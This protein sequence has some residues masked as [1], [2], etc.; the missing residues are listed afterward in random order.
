[1][2]KSMAPMEMRFAERPVR[3][4]MPKAK[5]AAKGMVTAAMKVM[6]GSP[7]MTSSTSVTRVMPAITTCQTVWVVLS[8]SVG[9]VVE[10]LDVHA[11]RQQASVVEVVD[12]FLEAF[13]SGERF[14]VF[15]EQD[16][17]DDDVVLL[18]GADLTEARLEAFSYFGDVSDRDRGA[19][20][21]S[22]DDCC[23]VGCRCVPVRWRGR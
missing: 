18:V 6:R 4:I 8:M 3:T 15:L 12:F 13:E 9:A 2:P 5:S 10:R 17:A 23:D 20:L 1:M 21:F 22:D 16:D 19:V 11:G 14:F 7:S